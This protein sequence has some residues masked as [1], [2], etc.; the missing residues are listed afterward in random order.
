MWKNAVLG[1][2]EDSR[3]TYLRDAEHFSPERSATFAS[4][5][6][7]IRARD[8]E[9]SSDAAAALERLFAWKREHLDLAR[10]VERQE[11]RGAALNPHDEK[12]PG[13]QP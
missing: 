11:L 1:L 7:S 8:W 13:A 2:H 4:E 12:P 9:P 3:A 10:D 6:G 5:N